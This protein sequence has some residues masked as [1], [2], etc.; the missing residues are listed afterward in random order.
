MTAVYVEGVGM[1]G[2]GLN[3]WSESA[4]ILAGKLPY[5]EAPAII[6]AVNLL[7]ANERRRMVQTVRLALALGTEAFEDAGRDPATIAT[8]FTSSGGDGETINEILTA[9][10]KDERE[11]SPT[12][13]HNS[14]HNAP[15][16]Y[17]SI[18]VGSREPASSLCCH[19]HSFAAGLL[20]STAQAAADDRA[21]AL[22]A[23]DL[24]YPEPLNGVRS[25]VAPFAV[26]LLIAPRPSGSSIARLDVEL[27]HGAAAASRMDDGALEDLRL[28]NP[29][30][31]SLPLLAALARKGPRDVMIDYAPTGALR[32]AVEPLTRQPIQT[33][34]VSAAERRRP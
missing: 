32:L 30:A 4:P 13:F 14:V 5:V 34:P 2:P 15:S 6:P 9:L 26:S 24:P 27:A 22:I 19:D 16:G 7:P 23:Y 21:V 10:A 29:A 3:G 33:E 31:R 12:R 28:G 8:V 17:W 25:I 18:A 1:R 11:I 20:E